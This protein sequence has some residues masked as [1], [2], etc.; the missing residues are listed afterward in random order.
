[1][2]RYQDRNPIR[3]AAILNSLP[4]TKTQLAERTGISQAA[5]SRWCA[6]LLSEEKIHFLKFVPV[7]TKFKFSPVYLLGPKPPGS[8]ITYPKER[9]P[10]ER[11]RENRARLKKSGEWDR[12]QERRK[13]LMEIDAQRTP[14]PLMQAFYGDRK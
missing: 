10:L 2:P 7:G 8:R 13:A 6:R 5:I 14:H 12:R 9:T 4:A 3:Q 11:A 1:M